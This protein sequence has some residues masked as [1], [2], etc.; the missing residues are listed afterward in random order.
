MTHEVP[1][2]PAATESDPP[3]ARARA[4]E[5]I[6]EGRGDPL[7]EW[8]AETGST[9]ADLLAE[10]VGDR[11]RR[12]RVRIADVQLAGRG[13]HDRAWVTSVGD[14][15]LMSVLSWCRP[16]PATLGRANAALAVAAAEAVAALGFAGVAV[17]WPNDLV[18]ADAIQA[19]LAGVL[20]Q[21]TSCGD[22][23]A[24]VSGIGLNVRRGDLDALVTDRAT[25]ALSDLGPPP[26]RVALAAEV[27]TR[28]DPDAN[29]LW[30]RYRRLSCTLGTDVEVVEAD[31]VVTGRALDIDPTGALLV[32]VHGTVRTIVAGDVTSLRPTAT[33]GDRHRHRTR[34]TG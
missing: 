1:L 7:V 22:V 6:L 3:A 9:N 4:L 29:D 8:V 18:T 25:V 32:E 20:A 28:F 27:L 30:A 10:A 16:D 31:T 34:D 11:Q 19:K 33:T 26:D 14:A 5:V 2:V 12:R 24:V 13:R 15:L 17:K 23:V 21:A